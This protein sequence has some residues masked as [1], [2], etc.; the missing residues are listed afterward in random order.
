MGQLNELSFGEALEL[1]EQ[2]HK[3]TNEGWNGRDMYIVKMNG[4]EEVRANHAT[5][6]AHRIHVGAKITISPYIAMR[7]AEGA[8]V[9]WTPSQMDLFSKRWK[10]LEDVTVTQ[11]TI[12]GNVDFEPPSLEFPMISCMI[13]RG[14]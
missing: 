14:E 5:A 2:G 10:L 8:I 3:V 4:Y 13:L 9:P 6:R 12:S 7:N 1:L 11:R